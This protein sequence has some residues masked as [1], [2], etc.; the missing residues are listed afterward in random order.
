MVTSQITFAQFCSAVRRKAALALCLALCTLGLG[1]STSAQEAK[2]AGITT[3]DVSG[4]GTGAGQGTFATGGINLSGTIAGSYTDAN[5]VSH[6]FLRSRDGKVTTFDPPGTAQIFFPGFNGSGAIGLNAEG[7]AVGY[8]VDA[9]FAVHAYIRT[10]D[11][12]FLTFDWPGACT[13]SQNV[14]CH[15]SGVWDINALGVAVGPYEDTSGNFVAHCAIRFPDGKITTFEVP[16]SSMLAGQGTL[17]TAFS[18]L[19]QLGAITGLYYDSNNVFHGF[20][21]TPKGTFTDFEAPGADTTIEFNGTQ[22]SS[23]NDFGA[24]TGLYLDVNEVLHG[25]VRSPEGHFTDF[26]VPGAGM[27]SQ[28]F[29]GTIPQNINRFGDITGYYLDANNVYHAF[30][31]NTDGNFL[32][33]DAPGADTTAGDFNGTFAASNN[34]IGAI[35]G[36]YVDATNVAHGFLRTP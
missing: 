6:S 4:A 2:K 28:S 31:R 27:T 14:G 7:T 3:F 5:N 25:F 34:D 9:N 18:G 35:T 33:F 30:V 29:Q 26:D 17:P 24:I 22:P 21:R 13:T 15:G 20:L 23:I 10:P 16:G 1:L 11:G 8:F 19:N 12:K 32:T 36:Y